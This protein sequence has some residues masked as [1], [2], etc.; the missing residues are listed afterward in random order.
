MMD[1]HCYMILSILPLPNIFLLGLLTWTWPFPE[2]FHYN[3]K[4]PQSND[5]FQPCYCPRPGMFFFPLY[6]KTVPH[7]PILTVFQYFQFKTS[8]LFHIWVA[9][10]SLL[11]LL[12]GKQI[13]SAL[14][15]HQHYH[16]MCQQNPNISFL[17]LR[18]ATQSW[19][20]PYH[21]L[22]P[23]HIRASVLFQGVPWRGHSQNTFSNT[24]KPP[25]K[26]TTPYF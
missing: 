15:E 22:L 2:S 19:F 24:N 7:L 23:T 20:Y 3:P 5:R 12:R 6:L 11:S 8:L 16:Q 21:I 4:I 9:S 17:P 18:L 26:S 10:A 14:T 13:I 25:F 1:F